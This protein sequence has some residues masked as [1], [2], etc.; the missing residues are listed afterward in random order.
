[1]HRGNLDLRAVCVYLC[2][3]VFGVLKCVRNNQPGARKAEKVIHL[4]QGVGWGHF[5][6]GFPPFS[7]S[8]LPTFT[9]LTGSVVKKKKKSTCQCRRH[10]FDAWVGKISQRRKWQPIPVF[11]PGKS[12]GQRSLAAYSPWGC[13]ESNMTEHSET[14][15]G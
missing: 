13:K 10:R 8:R 7:L 5:G 15:P 14:N 11:L 12:H 9:P 2:V 3:C 6:K 1:M 4:L